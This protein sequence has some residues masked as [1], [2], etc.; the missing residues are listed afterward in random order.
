MQFWEHQYV[1]DILGQPHSNLIFWKEKLKFFSITFI[2]EKYLQKVTLCIR[3]TQTKQI[4]WFKMRKAAHITGGRHFGNSCPLSSLQCLIA[5]KFSKNFSKCATDLK[6]I[7]VQLEYP[8][9]LLLTFLC[10]S[11]RV[12]EPQEKKRKPQFL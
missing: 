6:P 11:L 10:I 5:S 2:Q 3:C 7:C 1:S 9:R 8:S 4:F 12:E